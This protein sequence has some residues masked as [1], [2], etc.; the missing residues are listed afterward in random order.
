MVGLEYKGNKKSNIIFLILS[1]FLTIFSAIRYG[2]G[3]DYFGYM[4]HYNNTPLSIVE[5]L[6]LK[7]HVRGVFSIIMCFFKN[8][9]FS[10][11]MFIVVLSIFM[12]SIVTYTIW[13]E[14]KAKILSLLIFYSMYYHIYMNSALRQGLAMCIFLYAF[15]KFFKEG[16]MVKYIILIL[17]G[18]TIHYSLLIMIL[19]PAIKWFYNKYAFNKKAYIILFSGAVLFFVLKLERII[20][21]V[22]NSL[23]LYI[24][25]ESSG[26]NILAIM[27]RI[28]LL[29]V[30]LILYKYSDKS[31]V[32]DFDRFQI[33]VYFIG[34]VIFIAVSNTPVLSRLTEYF[35]V[36]DVLIF[37]NLISSINLKNIKFIGI[38]IVGLIIGVVFIKDQASFVYQGSYY[39][40][41]IYSYPY[42][43]IFNKEDIFHYR[44]IEDKYLPPLRR[45]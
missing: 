2:S 23:G 18:S 42:V 36:L 12:M 32:D 11:E 8:L 10:Y 9:H 39:N 21:L 30:I 33:F 27:L 44:F 28:I 7:T 25:Y 24:P 37:A 29:S 41:S 45:N 14:S 35:S 26:P 31:K 5:T 20:P 16:K 6:Q 38:L 17:I 3:S 40:K 19:M 34:I 43:S 4:W 1:A 13:K 15:Y 22:G